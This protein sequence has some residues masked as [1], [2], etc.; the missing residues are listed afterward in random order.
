M[1]ECAV[2]IT[3]IEQAELKP[4]ERDAAPLAANEI[5]GPTRATLVSAGTEVNGLYIGNYPASLPAVPG[6]AAVFAV[7]AVGSAVT[8]F[9]AGDLAFC[10]G[11]HRSFQR[12]AQEQALHLPD[13]LAP[14]AAVFA[15]L[16]G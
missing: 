5:T 15:R 4:L 9:K 13:G 11:P 12:I 10:A 6:Y 16:M 8:G 1:G 3:R 14:E 7:E 2:T